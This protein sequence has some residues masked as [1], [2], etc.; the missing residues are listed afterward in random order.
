MATIPFDVTA[1]RTLFSPAFNN[2]TTYPDDRLSALWD[3]AGAYI[4]NCVGASRWMGISVKQQVYMLQLMT[5][6]LTAIFDQITAAGAAGNTG[7]EISAT[8]DKISVTMQA[9]IAPNQWQFWLQTTPYGQMLL[10][11]LQIAAAGGRYFNP[12]PVFTA[13]RR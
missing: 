7:L 9:F 6:H 8:I 11:L 10:S 2:T 3:M 13:F 5:A 12:A 1:F 4:N